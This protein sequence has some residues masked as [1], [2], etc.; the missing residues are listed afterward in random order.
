MFLIMKEEKRH[1]HKVKEFP[2]LSDK[3]AKGYQEKDAVIN[4]RI[5]S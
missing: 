4:A 5:K 3:A 2:V 1:S